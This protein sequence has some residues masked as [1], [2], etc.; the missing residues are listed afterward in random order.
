MDK[1]FIIYV[2]G[3]NLISL[4]LCLADK[5]SAVKGHW[6]VSEKTL[7]I[8]SL[9]GGAPLM[10][11]SMRL[12]HHKTRHKRFMIGLPIIIILQ[13]LLAAFFLYVDNSIL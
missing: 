7:F 9:L 10:Y 11:L 8:V 5:R 12:F 13:V 4:I 6:R 1:Y 3:L 2:I